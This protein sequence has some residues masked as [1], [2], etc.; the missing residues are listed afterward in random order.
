MASEIHVND[1]GTRFL[2]TVKD[3]TST[4][5]V[6]PAGAT[7]V[8]TFKRPDDTTIARTAST[9][10]DGSAVSGVMYYDTIAGDLN[11]AGLWKIQ[12][13]VT[14]SSGTFYTDIQGFNVHCNL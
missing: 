7:G 13:K 12:G 1:I 14:I 9:L 3:G 6:S 2:V 4:V 8:L 11:Q 10:T 5:D